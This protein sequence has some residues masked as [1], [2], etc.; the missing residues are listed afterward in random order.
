MQSDKKCRC[1]NASR[2]YVYTGPVYAVEDFD[3]E[4]CPWC[5]ADGTAHSKLE[6]E[7]HDCEEVP[8]WAFADAPEVSESIIEEICQRTPGFGGW[9]QEQWATC[10][11]DGAA[12]LGRAGRYELSEHWPDAI[13]S[14]QESTGLV[15]EQWEAFFNALTRDGS[16][17]AFVFRCLHCGR[18]LGYQDAN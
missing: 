18:L 10:C 14:I 2:G 8:G 16:P 1:C 4:I 15:G 3:S 7:F 17:T 11:D 12:F 6:A 9:Q 5:I 13:E